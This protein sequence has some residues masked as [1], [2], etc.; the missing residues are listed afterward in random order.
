M[1]TFRFGAAVLLASLALAPAFA[2]PPK[3]DETQEL[4]GITWR[5]DVA[6]A[7]RAAQQSKP[8]KP[9]LL[10]RVLGDLDGGC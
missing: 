6:A 1:K 7:L 3:A 9:V 8:A 5:R 4:S 2:G 10:L